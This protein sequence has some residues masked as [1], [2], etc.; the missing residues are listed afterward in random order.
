MSKVNIFMGLQRQ[1]HH[2]GTSVFLYSVANSEHVYSHAQQVCTH[3][4][5]I[6][7]VHIHRSVVN[8]FHRFFHPHSPFRIHITITVPP[9]PLSSLLP[10]RSGNFRRGRRSNHQIRKTIQFCTTSP[11]CACERCGTGSRCRQNQ[12][13]SIDHHR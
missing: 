1:K 3:S 6:L 2:V 8:F 11:R 5:I 13:G 9:S 10:H 7:S 4:H 12:R